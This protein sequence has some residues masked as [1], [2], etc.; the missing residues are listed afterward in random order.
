MTLCLHP[1]DARIV[2]VG[3]Y[4]GVREQCGACRA[5][6]RKQTV[7]ATRGG[8]RYT[9]VRWSAWVG[10]GEAVKAALLSKARDAGSQEVLDL[11][12]PEEALATWKTSVKI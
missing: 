11:L 2:E 10:A 1:Q 6:R 8:T 9:T 12:T 3:S 5:T 4:G 7:M